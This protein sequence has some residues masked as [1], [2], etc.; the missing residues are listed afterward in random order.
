M[1]P[2]RQFGVTL[3]TKY[4][5]NTYLNIAGVNKS[6]YIGYQIPQNLVQQLLF[7]NYLRYCFVCTS[8]KRKLEL[9]RGILKKCYNGVTFL[10]TGGIIDT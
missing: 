10:E 1:Y 7:L 9:K 2:T 3:I 5:K 4:L 8:S 6:P